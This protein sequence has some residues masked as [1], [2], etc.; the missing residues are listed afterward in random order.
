MRTHVAV[1]LLATGCGYNPHQRYPDPDSGDPVVVPDALPVDQTTTWPPDAL[2]TTPDAGL[3]VDATPMP[4]DASP[5]DRVPLDRMAADVLADL[6]SEVLADLADAACTSGE[7][8][9][10]SCPAPVGAMFR[11]CSVA[12]RWPECP[13]PAPAPDAMPLTPDTAPPQPDSTLASTQ[14]D[15]AGVEVPDSTVGGPVLISDVLSLDFGTVVATQQ[16]RRSVLITNIGG[17]PTT[18]PLRIS[19]TDDNPNLNIGSVST[20]CN[21]PIAP[22]QGCGVA[23][24]YGAVDYNTFPHLEDL[25]GTLTVSDGITNLTIPVPGTVEAPDAGAPPDTR[26]DSRPNAVL[27]ITGGPYLGSVVQGSVGAEVVFTVTNSSAWPSGALAVSVNPIQ[28][29]STSIAV[30]TDTCSGAAISGGGVCTVGLRL[31]PPLS[32]KVGDVSADLWVKEAT[33]WA[34]F[35]TASGNIPNALS[36]SPDFVSFGLVGAGFSSDVYTVTITNKSATATGV[37]SLTNAG[38]EIHPTGVL[39]PCLYSADVPISANTCNAAL[40]PGASCSFGVQYVPCF[41]AMITMSGTVTVSDGVVGIAVY[42]RGH[43]S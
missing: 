32:A 26:P 14:T 19:L 28:G 24:D 15:S 36:A 20:G 43:N 38:L 8:S 17:S 37:L 9:T 23:L 34:A 1:L 12:G 25:N 42:L 11:A 33:F 2:P 3:R 5:P 40:S 21:R 4:R 27:T 41:A 16:S 6:R 10:C 13:C 7:I 29:D 39:G 35:A 22:G 18:V 30:S 31:A